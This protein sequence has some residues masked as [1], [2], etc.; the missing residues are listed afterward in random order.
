MSNSSDERGRGP[1]Q[2]TR[3][4][5]LSVAA[6]L[7]LARARFA[8]AQQPRSLPRDVLAYIGTYTP[9]GEGIYLCS[10]NPDYGRAEVAKNV[11]GH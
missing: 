11:Q 1:G 8:A 2:V 10:M 7:T 6:T 5:V 3:R 9:N 4:G